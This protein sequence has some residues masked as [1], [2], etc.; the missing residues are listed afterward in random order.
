MIEIISQPADTR[1]RLYDQIGLRLGLHPRAVEKDLWVTG[2]L[3][4]LFSLPYA[5]AFVF[6]KNDDDAKNVGNVGKNVGKNVGND[7]KNDVKNDAKNITESQSSILEIVSHN[8]GISLDA[9]AKEIGVSAPTIDREISKMGHILKHIGPKN[10][11]HWEII[12]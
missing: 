5:Q 9:I 1:R 12:E 4:T 11:G 10:G 6:K 3:Q 8:P 2:V 7:V